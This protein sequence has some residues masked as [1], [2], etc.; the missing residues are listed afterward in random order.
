MFYE[1]LNITVDI[2]K[3]RKDVAEKVFTL[4]DPIFQGEE[5]GYH[6]FG[7][8]SLLSSTGKWQD[9][10][11]MDYST[12]VNI[13]DHLK[14]KM[15]K[16]LGVSEGFENNIPTEGCTGEVAKVLEDIKNAGFV[17]RRARVSCLKPGGKTILHTDAPRD[18]YMARIHIPLWTNERC[19][20]NCEGT[21]LHMP[22]D[23]SVYI[24]WVNR[25][26]QVRNEWDQIRYHIIMDAYDVN[27]ITKNFKFDGSINLLEN[28]A[29]EF[30]KL[31]NE[32]VLTENDIRYFSMLEDSYKALQAS[33][34]IV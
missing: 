4:G 10:W 23:G 26:H 6:N 9:G 1:K 18:Q 33:K 31:M 21:D 20:H 27:S 24:L 11:Q 13:P 30:R 3:L 17:I 5:Y 16:Y 15:Q 12:M 25:M 34:K 14:A 32:T 19:V 22:A 7:G 2:E 28:K 29:S 8:W